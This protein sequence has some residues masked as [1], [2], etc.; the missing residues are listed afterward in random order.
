[1]IEAW[2]LT[3]FDWIFIFH[4]YYFFL[5]VFYVFSSFLS[6]SVNFHS[7][8]SDCLSDS[9]FCSFDTNLFFHSVDLS[10]ALLV[11]FGLYVFLVL[12]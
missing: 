5:Y 12:C 2:G 9:S 3:I 6:F 1:M 11:L 10:S 4:I 8:S 7:L